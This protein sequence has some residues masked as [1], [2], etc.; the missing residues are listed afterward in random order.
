[1]TLIWIRSDHPDKGIRTLAAEALKQI[2]AANIRQ[3]LQRFRTVA[4]AINKNKMTVEEIIAAYYKAQPDRTE[5]QLLLQKLL[6]EYP[7]KFQE[8]LN[9]AAPETQIH[10]DLLS[11][12]L[13]SLDPVT[14]FQQIMD[15]WLSQLGKVGKSV[16]D[17]MVDRENSAWEKVVDIF[18]EYFFMLLD[19]DNPAETDM[20]RLMIELA[21]EPYQTAGELQEKTEDGGPSILDKTPARN[22]PQSKED[23]QLENLWKFFDTIMESFR[24]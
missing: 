18:Y 12:C 13:E 9:S 2:N 19:L 24:K 14:D 11:V 20:A 7:D 23:I 1:M 16:K 3:Q 6:R 10:N 4:G 21:P 22:R 5:G 17:G 8:T 15:V